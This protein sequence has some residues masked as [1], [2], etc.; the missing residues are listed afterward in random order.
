MSDAKSEF[1]KFIRDL[2]KE[3]LS[4]MDQTVPCIIQSINPD[5][6]LN[7][8]LLSDQSTIIPNII[9]GSRYDFKSGDVGVLYKIKNRVSNSF[10]IAKY[11][12]QG[13]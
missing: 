1:V 6:T 11:N 3:Q 5:N 8:Y 2:V 13:E 12:A 4:E 10:V 7:I 9:N